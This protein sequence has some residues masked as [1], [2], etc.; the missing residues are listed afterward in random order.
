MQDFSSIELNATL[1]D[2]RADFDF[3]F[4]DWRVQHR[5]LKRRLVGETAW[6]A[7]DGTCAA[8]P[9]LGGLGNYDDNVLDGPGDPYRALTV[10][11]FDPA[12]RLWS[13]WW[14]DTRIASATIDPPT[15]GGFEDGVGRFFCDDT[16]D[17]RPIRVRYLW[18]EIARESLRWQQAFSVDGGRT[19]ETNWDMRFERTAW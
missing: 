15:V 12:A 7:F 5:K 10:R 2:G 6:D 19:W 4:G 8:R 18:S 17:G 3:L 13:I 1:D 11:R 14:I 16:F 9:V